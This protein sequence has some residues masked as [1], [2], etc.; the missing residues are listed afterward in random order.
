MKRPSLPDQREWLR[1]VPFWIAATLAGFTAV[2]IAVLCKAVEE[3]PRHVLER[4]PYQLLL[5]APLGFLIAWALVHYFAPE[6]KGSGIP[7][8]MAAVELQSKDL[9]PPM[10]DDLLSVR[11][12]VVKLISAVFNL[13]GGGAIGREGP[14]IQISA[15]IFRLIGERFNRFQFVRKIRPEVWMVT[16]SAAGIAAAFNT[17]LG[18]LVFAIE[19]LTSTHFASFRT[20][21]ITAV[22]ISG[23]SSQ[24]VSG[25]YLY[26]GY[27]NIP[28][29]GA[30]TILWAILIGVVTG[31]AGAWFGM[32]LYSLSALRRKIANT[33]KKMALVA[34]GAGVIVALLA[35]FFDPRGLG[36]GREAVI[37]L[38]FKKAPLPLADGTRP[39]FANADF[40]LAISRF[41][42]PILAY[43]TGSAGGI[44]APA[45]A[46]GGSLGS[47]FADLFRPELANLF[48]ILGMI[49]FLTAVTHAPFTAFVLVLEM[50]NRHTAILP[51]MATALIASSI[52]KRWHLE[53]FYER[54][55]HDY[56]A[57][58]PHTG[59]APAPSLTNV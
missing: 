51:M 53:S 39:G 15:G 31:S 17:P 5:I 14:T 6:A 23:I 41:V 26:L 44:F 49:G 28:V 35:I 19:E 20:S 30:K 58:I 47:L 11:T 45:L 16:G 22:I 1:D 56:L 55:K 33:P 42:T 46:A 54:V 34:I 12:I 24:W 32:A 18:G 4:H 37:N 9:H 38:L 7:Q 2:G 8:V 59:H 13:L 10:A 48:I 3:I 21:L 27:P 40:G 57:D 50:T 29:L 52:A 36:G 43:I 25:T